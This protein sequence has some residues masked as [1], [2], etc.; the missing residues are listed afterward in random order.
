MPR[1]Q[2][3]RFITVHAKNKYYLKENRVFMIFYV[4]ERLEKL[5]LISNYLNSVLESEILNLVISN[6]R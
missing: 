4:A 5:Q 3:F 6:Y 2:R 1:I